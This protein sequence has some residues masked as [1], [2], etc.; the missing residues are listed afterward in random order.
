MKIK[1]TRHLLL[2]AFYFNFF[3]YPG[4]RS[5]NITIFIKYIIYG[6]LG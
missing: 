2:V 4:H 3:A 6:L 1:A 5:T